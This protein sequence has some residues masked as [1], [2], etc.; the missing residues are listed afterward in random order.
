MGRQG[1]EQLDALY[2]E[3][4]AQRQTQQTHPNTRPSEKFICRATPTFQKA[5]LPLYPLINDPG[6]GSYPARVSH[7]LTLLQA[8]RFHLQWSP[9]FCLRDQGH[10][11]VLTNPSRVSKAFTDIHKRGARVLGSSLEGPE[12]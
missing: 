2:T 12:T 4:S 6:A 7:S 9:T 3:P 1:L 10:C 11:L 5:A 8:S